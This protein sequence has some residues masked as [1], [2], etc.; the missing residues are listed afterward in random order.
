M[1]LKFQTTTK[2]LEHRHRTQ[3]QASHYYTNWYKFSGK[4]EKNLSRRQ[5][6]LTFLCSVK[7]PVFSRFSR[8][9]PPYSGFH[10]PAPHFSV[11]ILF[12]RIVPANK[13]ILYSHLKKIDKFIIQDIFYTHSSLTQKNY[14]FQPRFK[15]NKCDT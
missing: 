15:I 6:L 13:T 12:T 10:T 2:V 7:F 3:H 8:D 14:T 9:W 1:F 4:I 11:I 5:N